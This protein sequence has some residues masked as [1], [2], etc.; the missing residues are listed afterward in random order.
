MS[1]STNKVSPERVPM[2]AVVFDRT[3]DV[4]PF[5][6]VVPQQLGPGDVTLPHGLD[7]E[8]VPALRG[9]WYCLHL[10][11][12]FFEVLEVP[13]SAMLEM[14]AFDLGHQ[15]VLT[16]VAT[17][18]TAHAGIRLALGTPVLAVCPDDLLEATTARC[19]ELD[20]A[21]PPISYSHLSDESL[22]SHWRAIYELVDTEAPYLGAPPA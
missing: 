8:V 5:V 14:Q 2:Y 19:E 22:E 20:F 13:P 6:P 12:T 7:R 16:P 15:I 11:N 4:G 9:L 21:L 1:A 17:L 10:P 18:T 3:V